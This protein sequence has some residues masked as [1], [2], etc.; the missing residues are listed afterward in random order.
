MSLD[1]YLLYL[2]NISFKHRDTVFSG[3]EP[4]KS[5]YKGLLPIFIGMALIS[6]A[7]T[8]SSVQKKEEVIP[9]LFKA[10]TSI[11][12]TLASRMPEFARSVFKKTIDSV[13][14]EYYYYAS[15]GRIDSLIQKEDEQYKAV[16]SIAYNS[17]NDQSN[18]EIKSG[19]LSYSVKNGVLDAELD[20]PRYIKKYWS[21]GN[22]KDILT[23]FL[24]RDDQGIIKVDSGRSEVY[25]ES[26][27]IYQQ[28]AWKDKR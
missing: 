23:G 15:N 3:R 7:G 14:G 2:K 28:N 18:Y 19:N 12:D 5:V 21:N 17:P 9:N 1:K 25:F 11:A 10:G 26:G 13:P 20:F 4:M 24:Y 6:C 27:K 22:P 16:A 8:D